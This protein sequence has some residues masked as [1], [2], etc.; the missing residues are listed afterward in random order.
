MEL[1]S[2]E[3][4]FEYRKRIISWNRFC[5][6]K[7]AVIGD[8]DENCK[9]VRKRGSME[10]VW[11]YHLD[12]HRIHNQADNCS[13]VVVRLNGADPSSSCSRRSTRIGRGAF[14]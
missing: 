1:D 13:S 2:N 14:E 5:C 9:F 4:L 7:S 8:R 11:Q 3:N 12:R 10:R 6:G